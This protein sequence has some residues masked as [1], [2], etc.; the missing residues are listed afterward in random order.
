MQAI[1]IIPIVQLW[2]QYYR[3]NKHEAGQSMCAALNVF[4]I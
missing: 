1:R 2:K 4:F 3:R